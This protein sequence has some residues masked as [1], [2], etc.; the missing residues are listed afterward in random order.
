MFLKPCG[1]IQET[2]SE[3]IDIHISCNAPTTNQIDPT[4]ERKFLNSC[5]L[6]VKFYKHG[7]TIEKLHVL[8]KAIK[9][10]IDPTGV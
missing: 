3:L 4:I 5:M 9:Q 6:G 7:G 10:K 8:Y 2:P 1:K